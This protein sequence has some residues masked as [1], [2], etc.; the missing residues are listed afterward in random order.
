MTL[1]GTWEQAGS[2]ELKTGS[3]EAK[4]V[5]GYVKALEERE[6][7]KNDDSPLFR[8][9]EQ[10]ESPLDSQ[11]EAERIS[12]MNCLLKRRSRIR[13][14]GELHDLFFS[15][16]LLSL[17]C[18]FSFVVS[19]LLPVIRKSSSWHA[20]LAS[21][22]WIWVICCGEHEQRLER[23]NQEIYKRGRPKAWST[24]L[25]WCIEDWY[26]CCLL[27]TISFLSLLVVQ[28]QDTTSL[29]NTAV[30]LSG[31]VRSLTIPS[32]SKNLI[33]T[34]MESQPDGVD[35]FLRFQMA[36]S[37]LSRPETCGG[38]LCVSIASK[39][40]STVKTTKKKIQNSWHSLE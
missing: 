6:I 23:E 5:Q 36:D 1:L 26:L 8:E 9:D 40:A 4:D 25:W 37:F 20:A 19:N 22:G 35:L 16:Y 7:V 33:Q 14:K 27:V 38:K 28:D 24:A 12:K 32:V 10:L 2:P 17:F 39:S 34:L 11:E 13:S 21:R 30:C 29:R 18:F 3:K 31:Q 15:P